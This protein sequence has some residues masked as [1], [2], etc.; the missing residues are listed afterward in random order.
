MARAGYDVWC[1]N[2][3]GNVYSSTNA[4]INST[5]NYDQFYDYDFEK[6]GEYDLPAQINKA[7]STTGVQ[8]LTYVGHS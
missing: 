7:I 6:L 2:N 3:R 1:G 4:N 8:K 5:D